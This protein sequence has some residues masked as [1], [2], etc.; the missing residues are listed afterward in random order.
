MWQSPNENKYVKIIT[1][2]SFCTGKILIYYLNPKLTAVPILL[3]VISLST[4]GFVNAESSDD[5]VNDNKSNST[6]T[7]LS[8]QT[9]VSCSQDEITVAKQGLAD[10]QKKMADIRTRYYTDWQTAH[11]VGQYNGT[12]EQYSHEKISSSDLSQIKLNYQKYNSILR[13]CGVAGHMTRSNVPSN[14]ACSQDDISHARQELATIMQHGTDLKNKI[15]QQFQADQSS[16]QFN[17]TWVQYA[18]ENFYN[19]PEALQLKSTHDKYTSFLKDC[20]GNKVPP[21]VMQNQVENYT[22]TILPTKSQSLTPISGPADA[23]GAISSHTIPGWVRGIAGWWA[24]G[25]I[26]DDEFVS[27]IKFLVHQGII[28]V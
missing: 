7:S 3:L 28:K 4:I 5:N 17:G 20:F 6:G 19:L 2:Q 9:S 12:F 18:K 14:T 8:D 15:Y 24:Q 13:S 11:N 25:K 26:S 23:L 10:I 21:I 27:A 16:G 22:S 1:A